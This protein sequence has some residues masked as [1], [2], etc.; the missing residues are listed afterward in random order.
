MNLYSNGVWSEYPHYRLKVD[1]RSHTVYIKSH[2]VCLSHRVRTLE[3]KRCV[4]GLT[5]GMQR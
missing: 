3:G 4:T 2:T 1:L 5:T